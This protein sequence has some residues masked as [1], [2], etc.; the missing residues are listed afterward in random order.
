MPFILGGTALKRNP[1]SGISV[2]IGHMLYNGNTSP[3]QTGMD[4]TL[5]ISRIIDI[6]AVYTDHSCILI[7]Q[8][9]SCFFG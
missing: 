3:Q 8:I 7:A 9:Q 5:L 1:L 2:Q 6:V 4:G